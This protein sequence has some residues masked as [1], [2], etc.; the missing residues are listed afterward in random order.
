[1]NL[2]E[3]FLVVFM[4]L[5]KWINKIKFLELDDV[6]F[7]FGVKIYFFLGYFLSDLKLMEIFEICV[8]K[9]ILV[10]IY[11]GGGFICYN[12]SKWVK[13]SRMIWKEG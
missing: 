6:F 12:N 3:D 10:I 4:D 13:G 7:F 11:C 5:D 1:M 2:Y 9:N 8:V